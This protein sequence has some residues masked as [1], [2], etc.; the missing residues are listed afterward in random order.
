MST[1]YIHVVPALTA[2]SGALTFSNNL[3]T[4]RVRRCPI[5]CVIREHTW[6]IRYVNARYT[7]LKV[8]TYRFFRIRFKAPIVP[9]SLLKNDLG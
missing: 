7:T 1:Y 3:G 8:Q 2:Q 6:Y 5:I 4:I 9:S